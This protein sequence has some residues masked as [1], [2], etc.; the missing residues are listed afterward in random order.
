MNLVTVEMCEMHDTP[1][2]NWTQW[3][4]NVRRVLGENITQ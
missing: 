2:L 3:N 4:L 1:P